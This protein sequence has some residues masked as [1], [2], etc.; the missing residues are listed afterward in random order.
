MPE[1]VSSVTGSSV[2]QPGIILGT[3]FG[4]NLAEL[5]LVIGISAFIGKKFSTKSKLLKKTEILIWMLIALPFILIIDGKLSRIDG[6]FMLMA[7]IGY[8][9]FLWKKEGKF[10]KIKKDVPLK[11]LWRDGLVFLGCLMVLLLSAR[12]LVFSSVILSKDF[13]I[14]AYFIALTVI[15]L[16][17]TIPDMM[18]GINSIKQKHHGI[19]YGNVIGSTVLKS[20]FFLGI[21]AMLRPISFGIKNISNICFFTLVMFAMALFWARNG[22]ISKKNGLFL[23]AGY[24]IFLFIQFV[25]G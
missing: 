20:L 14:P 3:I 2:N 4:S 17:A 5:A 16:G 7:F 12:Y 8:V 13:G 6:F 11:H 10:G 19:G 25:I 21:I 24:L 22:Y 23:I 18:V 15:A 1:L 9:I